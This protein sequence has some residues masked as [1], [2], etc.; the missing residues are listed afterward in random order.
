[1]KGT[2]KQRQ[3]AA[4][5][6]SL[7][8][9]FGKIPLFSEGGFSDA[10][11]FGVIK[12]LLTVWCGPDGCYIASNLINGHSGIAATGVTLADLKGTGKQRQG[13]RHNECP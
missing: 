11:V 6:S 3:D 13:N 8:K 2:E 9:V 7:Q 12:R 4:G 1:V 10:T 5:I